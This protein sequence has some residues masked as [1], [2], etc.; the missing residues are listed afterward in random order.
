MHDANELEGVMMSLLAQVQKVL[1]PSERTEIERLIAEDENGKALELICR[2]A[3][4]QRHPWSMDARA[5]VFKLADRLGV[6]PAKLG[7]LD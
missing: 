4:A 5:M 1:S 3:A 6:D 7:M 2:S